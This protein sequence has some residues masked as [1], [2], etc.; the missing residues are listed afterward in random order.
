[1]E[2]YRDQDNG[3]V[4]KLL[5]YDSK[6]RIANRHCYQALEERRLKN[7]NLHKSKNNATCIENSEKRNI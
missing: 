7:R 3:I 4:Q 2:M 6:A 1:M 5:N